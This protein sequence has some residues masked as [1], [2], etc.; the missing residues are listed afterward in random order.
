MCFMGFICINT[1]A[2][3]NAI[4]VNS[5]VVT[6][7]IG[8]ITS[9][10]DGNMI[11]T[12]NFNATITIGG[13]TLTNNNPQP[14]TSN[15]N[16]AFI[17]KMN[18]A[19]SYTWAKN[20][21]INK[22]PS[23]KICGTLYSGVEILGVSTDASGNIYLTGSFYGSVTFGSITLATTQRSGGGTCGLYDVNIFTTKISPAGNFL[24]A[25]QEGIVTNHSTDNGYSV[26]SDAAGN[27]YT[28]GRLIQM[29]DKTVD[30][31]G[32]SCG[33]SGG[34]TLCP[35]LQLYAYVVKYNAAG[36][37][38]WEKKYANNSTNCD[39]SPEGTSIVSDG[40]NIYVAGHFIQTVNFG[41]GF[42]FTASTI[43][44]FLL[45]LDGNGNTI[46][47]TTANTN[48]NAPNRLILDNEA[49]DIY[50]SGRF[51]GTSSFGTFN[52]TATGT[53]Q[54]LAKYAASS[55]I[56]SWAINTG[57]NATYTKGRP[58]F[59]H[60]NGN[61]GIVAKEL[62][63]LFSIKEYS[64]A[65]SFVTETPATNVNTTDAVVDIVSMPGGFVYS[66]NIK[67]SYEIGGTA[68]VS[69]QPGTS[70]YRDLMLVKYIYT[71]PSSIANKPTNEKFN[72]IS[73]DELYVRTSQNPFYDQF[74]LLINSNNKNRVNIRVLDVQG[75]V[76]EVRNV[77]PNE[78]AIMIGEKLQ[79]GIYYAEIIQGDVRHMEKILKIE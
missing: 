8:S 62:G 21:V 74:S 46:W 44:L 16:A 35:G 5:Q 11:V 49:Q 41:N 54:Y 23:K 71:A 38:I 70:N 2:Q 66:Q 77:N 30:C 72:Q 45:K 57:Y 10:N 31:G 42:S 25:K 4:N 63:M 17:A 51:S 1:H 52:L 53:N 76:L 34:S 24:W 40:S 65:G 56:C 22:P 48:V 69:T 9:D 37:K 61:I 39:L 14:Y 26:T 60:P 6:K 33:S 43:N 18:S 27:V 59:K 36:T 15:G 28:T 68:I 3:Y 7:G 12:G 73:G 50:V 67:G 13:Y 55:G 32:G 64:T 75:R 58:A 20:I 78:G 79:P 29:E 19:G 47:A